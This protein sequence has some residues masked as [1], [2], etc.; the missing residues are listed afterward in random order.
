MAYNIYSYIDFMHDTG[1]FG[2][3]LGVDPTQAQN[4]VDLVRRELER[5]IGDGLEPGE[6]EAVKSQ[7]KGNLILGL[8]STSNRMN[9]LAKMEMY[10]NQYVSIEDTIADIEKVTEGEIIRLA[11][12]KLAPDRFTISLLGPESSRGVSLR[13]KKSTITSRP[14]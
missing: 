7:L 11:A 9:R 3:Y 4:A 14:S 8:E 1:L 13:N 12:E 2:I 6:L 5:L 10:L